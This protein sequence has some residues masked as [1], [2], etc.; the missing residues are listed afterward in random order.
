MIVMEEVHE[1]WRPRRACAP[2]TRP[3]ETPITPA[4][5][6]PWSLHKRST[7]QHATMQR[8]RAACSASWRRGRREMNAVRPIACCRRKFQ[9]VEACGRAAPFGWTPARSDRRDPREPCHCQRAG[10]RHRP[11]DRRRPHAPAVILAVERDGAVVGAG[12]QK[13][14]S[15]GSADDVEPQR[16]R[17]RRRARGR[18]T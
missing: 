3:P 7:S 8:L 2:G 6:G 17:V 10:L 11:C 13:T 4:A 12:T 14:P 15:P 16:E 18:G 1:R 9:F 5:P